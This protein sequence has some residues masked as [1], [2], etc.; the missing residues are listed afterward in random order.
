MPDC[1]AKLVAEFETVILMELQ[2]TQHSKYSDLNAARKQETE[3]ESPYPIGL[4]GDIEIH[5]LHYGNEQE[6]QEKWQ[7]RC[8]RIDFE[9]LYFIMVTNGPYNNS[10]LSQL[11]GN[12]P[13][14]KV[15]FHR[16]QNLDQPSCVYIPSQ[17]KDMGNLYSQYQ[18][19][20]GRFSFS[21]WICKKKN[22]PK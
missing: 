10:T 14:N 20:V 4:L 21:D 16:D 8:E 1:F 18:R 22:S 11:L 3:R 9:H 2:F 19:F 15:V 5:F 17:A 7:R 6:A 12:R 13:K